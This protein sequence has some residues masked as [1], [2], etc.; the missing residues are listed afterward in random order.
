MIYPV[1]LAGLQGEA[2]PTDSALPPH[3][4]AEAAIESRFQSVLRG[5]D[6]PLFAAPTVVACEA[7][8]FVAR[9]QMDAAGVSGDL[10]IEPCHTKTAALLAALALRFQHDPE[11]LLLILPAHHAE[12][13]DDA[14]RRAMEQAMP[15]AFRGDMVLVTGNQGGPYG[16]VR[17]LSRVRSGQPVQALFSVGVSEISRDPQSFCSAGVYLVRAGSLLAAFKRYAPRLLQSTKRAVAEMRAGGGFLRLASEAYGRIN[18]ESFETAI[19]MR[20]ETVVAICA[21]VAADERAIWERD[22]ALEQRNWALE[23]LQASASTL[24]A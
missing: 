21:D 9:Q 11:A 19:L 8:R 24:A 10:I 15:V 7:H 17:A 22:L 3:F 20:M 13:E 14:F 18:P 1:V 16:R 12:V 23:G 5:L 2:Q 6:H 4:C